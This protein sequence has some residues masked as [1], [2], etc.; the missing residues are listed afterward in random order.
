M[1]VSD[2]ALPGFTAAD[3][4]DLVRSQALPIPV[5]ILTSMPERASRQVNSE[6]PVLANGDWRALTVTLEQAL[7][8]ATVAL[9]AGDP[10][11]RSP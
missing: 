2:F 10:G 3:V 1:V 11:L 8:P 9:Q 7:P 6:V 5:I 4:V